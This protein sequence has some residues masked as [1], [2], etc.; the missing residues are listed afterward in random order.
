MTIEQFG[1]DSK[2]FPTNYQS[3]NSSFQRA[4]LRLDVMRVAY[5]WLIICNQMDYTHMYKI[6]PFFID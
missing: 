1:T 4:L 3:T 6:V 5:P 2:I